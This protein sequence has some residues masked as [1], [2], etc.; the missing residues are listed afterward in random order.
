MNDNRIAVLTP[1]YTGLY[2]SRTTFYNMYLQNGLQDATFKTIELDNEIFK[3]YGGLPTFIES[4]NGININ[5]TTVGEFGNIVRK[6]F[7]RYDNDGSFDKNYQQNTLI[8]GQ[9]VRYM[10]NGTIF[11]NTATIVEGDIAQKTYNFLKILPN[12]NIDSTFQL[13]GVKDV[14]GFEFFDENTL[15]ATNGTTLN[16]FIKNSSKKAEYFYFQALPSKIAWNYSYPLKIKIN[17]TLK[18]ININVSGNGIL[19]DSVINIKPQSGIIFINITDENNKILASQTIEV[20]KVTPNF[21]YEEPQLTIYSKPYIFKVKSS[22]GFPVKIRAY[23]SIFVDSLVIDPIKNPYLTIELSSD[24][25]DQY[26]FIKK[27]FAIIIL[28]PLSS[29]EE[30]F[31]NISFY[32]NPVKEKLIIETKT[33][34]DSFRLISI[35]GKTIPVSVES[36]EDKYELSVKNVPAG[37]YLLW[38]NG[39]K[40]QSIFRVWVE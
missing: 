9:Y 26:E 16:R 32:P 24:G 2:F 1:Y 28:S 12:G 6:R 5:Q 8:G 33:K 30:V 7:T 31:E 19:Q 40:K 34:L 20:T 11:T 36:F 22:S 21:I 27:T 13:S 14:F 15:Y 35:D 29:E 37:L 17:T 25:N 38:V 23:G 39:K 3:F 18:N 4:A 10:E